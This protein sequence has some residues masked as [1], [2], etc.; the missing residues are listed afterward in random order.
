MTNPIL[1]RIAELKAKQLVSKEPA[2][3]FTL[4]TLIIIRNKASR[5]CT[6]DYSIGLKAVLE[7]LIP[8]NHKPSDGCPFN[9][10]LDKYP[11]ALNEG[12]KL[13]CTLAGYA[14][15][16][17]ASLIARSY[18]TNTKDYLAEYSKLVK[19]IVLTSFDLAVKGII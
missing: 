8:A 7:Y 10:E 6:V 2:K 12:F 18:T 15:S 5:E 17:L 1:Q 11:L 13:P 3:L 4:S 16:E 14:S 19:L 9:L